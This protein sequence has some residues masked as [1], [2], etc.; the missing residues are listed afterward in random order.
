M[1][2]GTQETFFSIEPVMNISLDSF[3]HA[4]IKEWNMFDY[5]IKGFVNL[6]GEVPRYWLRALLVKFN[7]ATFEVNMTNYSED[8]AKRQFQK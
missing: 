2:W 8:I 5:D 1:P 6:K 4:A 3:F 7:I